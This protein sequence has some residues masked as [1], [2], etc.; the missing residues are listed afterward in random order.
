MLRLIFML[1]YVQATTGIQCYFCHYCADVSD[2]TPIC[3]GYLC[4][5][6]FLR[7]KKV[8]FRYCSSELDPQTACTSAR[9]SLKSNDEIPNQ[10][11]CFVCDKQLCNYEHF[12]KEVFQ[13]QD[14]DN[15]VVAIPDRDDGL[16][17]EELSGDSE[18]ADAPETDD[19]GPNG[20]GGGGGN[21][22]GDDGGNGGGAGGGNGGG[23]GG[24]NGGGGNGASTDAIS[25]RPILYGQASSLVSN[26]IL[27]VLIIV[28]NM[29]KNIFL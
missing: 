27:I 2:E 6:L 29:F 15:G 17:A 10:T 13:N 8:T 16:E 1:L 4:L 23:A 22:G 7:K 5:T 19:D 11:D 24:G 14:S 25:L 26:K 12:G 20:G 18:D 21:G 3:D 9:Q 28:F